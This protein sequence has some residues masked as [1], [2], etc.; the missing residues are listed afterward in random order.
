[1]GREMLP[2]I[3]VREV[4]FRYSG[5]VDVLSKVSFSA[6]PG[7]I[8]GFLGANGAGKTSLFRLLTGLVRPA[9]G[10]VEV[11]GFDLPRQRLDA[12][13]CIGFVPDESLL[14]SRMS[15]LENLN[16][17]ALLWGVPGGEA[18]SRSEALLRDANLWDERHVWVEHYSRGMKQRLSL[19]CALLHKPRILI[20]DE[21]FNALDLEAA[22]WLRTLLRRAAANGDCILLSSHQAQTLDELADRLAVLEH[23]KIAA[24]LDRPALAEQGGTE[25]V[26]LRICASQPLVPKPA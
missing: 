16:Q 7:E 12:N 14:Y 8:L 6:Q 20:L 9:S 26:F 17:F 19:I 10:T 5:G 25:A 15:A 1:M 2:G 24:L 4:S 3:Q 11:A 22:I 13:K 23:G 18:R 21:P